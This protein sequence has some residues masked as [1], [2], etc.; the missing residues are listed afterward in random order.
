MASFLLAWHRATV[1]LKVA[2]KRGE[3]STRRID[4]TRYVVPE[5]TNCGVG[6]GHGLIAA[7]AQ[8]HVA[9]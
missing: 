3:G 9:G 4:F 7:V 6:P 1:D 2:Y 5:Q 8:Y